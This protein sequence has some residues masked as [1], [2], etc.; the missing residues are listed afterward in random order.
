MLKS[1]MYFA[2]NGDKRHDVASNTTFKAILAGERTSTTRFSVWPQFSDYGRL[3]AG[4]VIRFYEQSGLKGRHVDVVVT[5]AP[6]EIDLATCDNAQLDA[7]SR[8]EGW[9]L[10]AGRKFG[11]KYGK[12]LQIR[13]KQIGSG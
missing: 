7:W 1:G 3:Q 8:A 12:G 9:S 5:E 13:Y 11:Q 6:A 2:F 4:D 10:R